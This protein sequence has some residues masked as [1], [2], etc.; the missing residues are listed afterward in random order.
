MTAS[1]LVAIWFQVLHRQFVGEPPG[2]WQQL[3][4]GVAVTTAAWI[5]TALLTPP[6]EDATLREFYRRIRPGGPGWE[7]VRR[8]AAAAGEALPVGVSELPL[9]IACAALGCVAVYAA[10]FASGL[11]LYGRPLAAA[12]LAAVGVGAALSILALWRRRERPSA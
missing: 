5:A 10:L 11:A 8:R 6:A 1:F 12:A 7:A 4:I 2:E 9:G 3:T